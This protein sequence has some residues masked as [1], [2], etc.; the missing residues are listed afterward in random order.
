VI[1]IAEEI[2][3][4]LALSRASKQSLTEICQIDGDS[5]EELTIKFKSGNI[6]ILR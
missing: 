6:L 2:E 3:R 5:I 4:R 1:T